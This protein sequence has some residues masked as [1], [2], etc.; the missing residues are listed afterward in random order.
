MGRGHDR[1]PPPHNV[2]TAT[3]TV[4]GSNAQE[5]PPAV[6][7]PSA[8]VVQPLPPVEQLAT[9]LPAAALEGVIAQTG[10]QGNF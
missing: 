3:P 8:A 6:V 1:D 9:V 7:P 2:P 10:V 5:E 4:T